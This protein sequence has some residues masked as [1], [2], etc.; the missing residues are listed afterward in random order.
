M[1]T[2]V[3]KKLVGVLKTE[4]FCISMCVDDLHAGFT[5]ANYFEF[6][7]RSPSIVHAV[8]INVN[9]AIRAHGDNNGNRAQEAAELA[10]TKFNHTIYIMVFFFGLTMRGRN[11]TTVV[12]IS[13][14]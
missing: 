1:I 4:K 7:G 9:N 8:N 12:S 13:H 11:E 2:L 14:A 6:G 3:A 5:Y 10:A